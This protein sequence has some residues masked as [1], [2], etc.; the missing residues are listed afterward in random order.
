MLVAIFNL[1][2]QY[3]D[4]NTLIILF[5][6]STVLATSVTN[7]SNNSKTAYTNIPLGNVAATPKSSLISLAEFAWGH[8]TK[9][10]TILLDE[11]IS[12]KASSIRSV[13]YPPNVSEMKS[14]NFLANNFDAF[15]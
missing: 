9:Y 13:K 14:D 4:K 2:T 5:M 1:R 8:N 11:N 3:F 7:F 12:I 10:S 6:L 15:Q